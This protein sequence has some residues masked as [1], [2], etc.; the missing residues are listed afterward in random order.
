MR[1]SVELPGRPVRKGD[2][3]RFLPERGQSATGL[4]RRLWQVIGFHNEK[5]QRIAELKKRAPWPISW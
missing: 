1:E 4:D 5:G 3:V 2:K